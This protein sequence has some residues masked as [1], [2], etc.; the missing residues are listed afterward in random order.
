M[1][2]RG[3]TQDPGRD[4][5]QSRHAIH[6][7]TTTRPSRTKTTSDRRRNRQAAN[8]REP[9]SFDRNP[10]IEDEEAEDDE[11]EEDGLGARP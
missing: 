8:A 10:R 5:A 3:Q 4:G 6:R 7:T 1:P 9:G 11:D 2:N